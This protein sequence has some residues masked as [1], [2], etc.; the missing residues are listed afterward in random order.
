MKIKQLNVIHDPAWGKWPDTNDD[1]YSDVL[2]IRGNRLVDGIEVETRIYP[3]Y[4]AFATAGNK[5]LPI[6]YQ[7]IDNTKLPGQAVLEQQIEDLKQYGAGCDVIFWDHAKN[8]YPPVAEYI[9]QLFKLAILPFA[10]D[11]PGS[12]EI[13]TFPVARYFDALFYQMKVWDFA[14]GERTADKY[15]VFYL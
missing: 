4:M 15:K 7:W 13:K 10:D 5:Q 8:C 1:D 11:C 6:D 2:A 3:A 9:P 14:T 12:S